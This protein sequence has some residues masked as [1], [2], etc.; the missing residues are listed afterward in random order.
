MNEFH[1]KPIVDST[2]DLT[3][4]I[5]KRH[6]NAAQQ[7]HPGE[8]A[9]AQCLLKYKGVVDV[10]IGTGI[11]LVEYKDKVIRYQID[12]EDAKKITAFDHA[13]Y[14][15]PGTIMFHPPGKKI[16]SRVGEKHGSE[17]REG[18]ASTARGQDR[19][20]RSSAR[21]DKSGWQYITVPGE[22]IGEAWE[23]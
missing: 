2:E 13:N 15:Q 19:S 23:S 11:A 4:S 17:T 12:K 3:L 1:G 14:F 22:Q 18:K 7:S 5:A 16:G 21:T 8:C 20:T 10:R 6:I 9:I